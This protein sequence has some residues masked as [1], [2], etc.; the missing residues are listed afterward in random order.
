MINLNLIR[1]LFRR[2]PAPELKRSPNPARQQ[3]VLAKR[4]PVRM[5]D[6]SGK[7]GGEESASAVVLGYP[8]SISPLEAAI[9]SPHSDS[10]GSEDSSGYSSGG[11][12]SGGGDSGSGGGSCD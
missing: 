12:L 11:S 2:P 7:K 3:E 8:G 1:A 4:S 9:R 6:S 5:R 10:C